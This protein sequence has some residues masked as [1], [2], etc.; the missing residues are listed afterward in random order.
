MDRPLQADALVIFGATGDLAFRKIYPALQALVQGDRLSVPVIGM[1]RGGNSLDELRQRVIDSVAT[2]G[3]ED[4][5]SVAELTGQLDYVDG[6]YNDPGT[7]KRLRQTL[8]AAQAPLYYLAIPPGM[9]ATVVRHLHASGCTTGSARVVV[10]K[11]F[12]R[13]FASARALN[14]VLHDAFE[15]DAI[16]RIDHFLG[17]EP[18]QNLLYFRFANAFLEPIWNRQ[19][20][21]SVQITMAES[22]GVEGRGRFYEEVGAIRDVV[23]NH[24]L[25]V[26]AHLAMEPP[27]AD[28]PDALRDAKADVLSRVA[29]LAAKDLVRGQYLGYR[30][31][32]DVDGRSQVETYAAL[33]LSIDSPR[34]R[35]VPFFIRAG[36]RLPMSVTEVTVELQRPVP[37]FAASPAA[38][39]NYFRFRLGPNR[40]VIALGA[41]SKKPG[42]KMIGE[43]VELQVCNDDSGYMSAYERLIGDAMKGDHTLFARADSVE[44]AWSVVE[45]V[46]DGATSLHVYEPGSW[47]PA[48]AEELAGAAGWLCPGCE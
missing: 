37:V 45:P 42:V 16:F 13:D 25:E 9:F 5:A 15:E 7:F 14:R 33:R 6:D 30:E 31:E 28:S 29:P 46:L 20:V 48:A 44:F 24:L 36:K 32:A 27:A 1:A 35:N 8:G 18:V 17:K 2:H 38:P 11:P 23:Q 47:G 3:T 22:I 34:W 4:K 10:E 40:T 12:G 43:P 41:L 19:H 26:V 21:A 39:P